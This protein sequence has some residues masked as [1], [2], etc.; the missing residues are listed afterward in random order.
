MSN[1]VELVN[2]LSRVMLCR[3]RGFRRLQ[4]G[5]GTEGQLDR[6]REEGG[7]ARSEEEEEEGRMKERGGWRGGSKGGGGGV[8]VEEMYN[9]RIYLI[10]ICKI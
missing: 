8:G 9:R 10:P 3:V 1:R 4:R 6:E 7:G 5:E 2:S